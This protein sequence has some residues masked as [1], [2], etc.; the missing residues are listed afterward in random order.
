MQWCSWK[1]SS[2]QV[3]HFLESLVFAKRAAKRIEK[4]FKGESSLYV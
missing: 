1:E 3:I 4:K 2:S